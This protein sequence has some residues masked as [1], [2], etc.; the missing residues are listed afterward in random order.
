MIRCFVFCQETKM[1]QLCW[2]VRKGIWL[3][4]VETEGVL[5]SLFILSLILQTIAFQALL[6]EVRGKIID[7]FSPKAQAIFQREIDFFDKVTSLSTSKRG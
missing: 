6:P 1:T 2:D 7:G 4:L 5:K 3:N